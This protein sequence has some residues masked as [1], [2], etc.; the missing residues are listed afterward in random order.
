MNQQTKRL[1]LAHWINFWP[2]EALREAVKMEREGLLRQELERC[3]AVMEERK[4]E[5]IIQEAIDEAIDAIEN[6]DDRQLVDW[7]MANR[8]NSFSPE[9]RETLLKDGLAACV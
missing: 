3:I 9:I 7:V 1:G 8:L 5:R 2:I 6:S 4:R